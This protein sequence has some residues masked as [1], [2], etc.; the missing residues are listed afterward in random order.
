MGAGNQNE[1]V[2]H[3]NPITHIQI[4]FK[5]LEHGF[6]GWLAK[7]PLLVE[8][9]VETITS[10]AHGAVIGGFVG[11]ITNDA[12]F[13][14]PAAPP[15]GA[16]LNSPA[17][18]F[19]QQ[20]QALASGP[21]IQA[22]DLAVIAGVNAGI[23]CVMKRLRGKEKIDIQTSMVAGF[24]SGA[25][26]TLVSDMGGP[27]LAANVLSSGVIFALLHGGLFKVGEKLSKPPVE[28]VYS[29]TKL[30][31][32]TLGLTNYEK[33][34]KKGLLTD[35]TLPLLTDRALRDVKIPPGPRLVILDHVQRNKD[36]K[37]GGRRA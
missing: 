31:L 6:K 18:A 30:M 12:A 37:K 29:E 24:G 33:N 25:M 22:R 28:D 14:F 7:K 15:S 26:Y 32:S 16:A 4:K 11:T 8:A 21:L 1:L 23:S 27:N 19:F 3:N 17:M 35:R 36:V 2:I 10:A 13:N 5:E 9:A 20:A 34:F